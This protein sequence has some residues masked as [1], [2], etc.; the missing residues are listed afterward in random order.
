MPDAAAILQHDSVDG[1]ERCRIGREFVQEGEHGLL[2]GMGD[3]ESCK[4]EALGCGQDFGQG[5]CVDAERLQIDQLVDVAK[6]LLG[7]FPLV[8]PRGSRCLDASSHQADENG[9]I[10]RNPCGFTRLGQGP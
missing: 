6:A 9:W 2:A 5:A 10:V 4:A 3:V 7:S 1:A 8:Q